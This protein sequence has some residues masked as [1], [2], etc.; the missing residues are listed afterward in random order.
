MKLKEIAKVQGGFAFK[1]DSFV[2]NETPIIRIGNIINNEIVIDKDIT[3]PIS[4][5]GD[6]KEFLIFK[7]DLLIA[8]SGATVGKVGIY[9]FDSPSMLN[10]RVGN[11]K[12][13][14]MYKKYIF[15]LLQ[16]PKFKKYVELS[17]IGCAQ[18]NISNSQIENFEF[19][20]NSI[21]QIEKIVRKLD[22]VKSLINIKKN[23]IEK[24]KELVKSQFVEM[25]GTIKN[26]KYNYEIKKLS[27]VFE[28]IKDGTHSTP[29]YTDDKIN[30]I[31]FL[32]AKDVTTGKINWSDIK[33]IPRELHEVLSKRV[34]PQKGDILLCKNGTTGICAKV[35]VD[36]IFDIYV[37]LALL[38]PNPGY[39]ID[40][41]VESINSFETK[42]Q[43]NSSLKGI[44]VP[45]LHLGEISNAKILVPPIELQNKFA[46][47]VEQIDK[48]KFV[49]TK[50]ARLLGKI[51]I[52]C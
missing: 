17:S 34:K 26:N 50:I 16:S 14:E 40:Y 35:D 29:T 52:L 6:R 15:Y 4:T 8:M 48:Q 45:N 31:K 32:S 12:S 10:Q 41:L 51:A 39:N 28:L 1:S 18:P 24:C 21:D 43:F 13:D 42:K 19:K 9:N 27:E 49:G 23:E 38:R 37:S 5:I 36:E 20:E 7:D 2:S 25:F 46:Q 33:Y 11:I 44:G 47:M 3:A 22:S 30:G